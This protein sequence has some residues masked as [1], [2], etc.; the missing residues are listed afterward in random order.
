MGRHPRQ[1]RRLR[2]LS[3]PVPL[4]PRPGIRQTTALTLPRASL[5]VRDFGFR[6]S[7]RGLGGLPFA[8]ES[9]RILNVYRRAASEPTV[10]LTK[11]RA[12]RTG[13]ADRS[14]HTPLWI[15]ILIVL[16]ASNS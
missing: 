11:R 5:I 16:F 10:D 1:W 12:R 6:A 2:G 8:S 15:L 13:R 3:I 4:A 9:T 14:E 7:P